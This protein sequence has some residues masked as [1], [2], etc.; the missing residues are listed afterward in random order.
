[1]AL[2]HAILVANNGVKV[3]QRASSSD[4]IGDA[5]PNHDNELRWHD[6]PLAQLRTCMS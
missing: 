1:M 5:Q 3:V 4:T 6:D 2:S